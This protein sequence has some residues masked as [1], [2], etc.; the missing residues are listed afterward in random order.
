MLTLTPSTPQDLPHILA[1]EAADDAA[2]FILPWPREQHLT[3]MAD[4]DC[5]HWAIRQA[6]TGAWLGFVMLFGLNSPHRAIELRRIVCAQKGA[7]LGRAALLAVMAQ[8]FGPLNAHRLWLDVKTSNARAYH[9]YRAVGFIEE[10]VLRDCLREGDGFASLRVMSLLER[11]PAA[12]PF[13]L[14]C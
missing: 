3:A 13:R 8:A 11:D 10:G 12:Q 7:G 14:S 2:P 4:P 1:A 9:L 5:A 6:D